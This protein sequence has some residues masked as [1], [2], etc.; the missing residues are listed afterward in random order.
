MRLLRFWGFQSGQA[1][2]YCSIVNFQLYLAII[3]LF[4]LL[5]EFFACKM[6]TGR[7][8]KQR[9][10]ERMMMVLPIASESM[11]F[12]LEKYERLLEIGGYFSRDWRV[13]RRVITI[14]SYSVCILEMH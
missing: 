14:V 10:V 4:H 13:Y 11:I 3:L 2:W 9:V 7:E 5:W 1:R 8:N 6:I 12:T